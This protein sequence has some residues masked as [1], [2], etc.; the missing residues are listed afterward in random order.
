VTVSHHGCGLCSIHRVTVVKHG[1]RGRIVVSGR[2]PPTWCSLG[3][4]ARLSAC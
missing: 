1:G 2:L 3:R 4:A